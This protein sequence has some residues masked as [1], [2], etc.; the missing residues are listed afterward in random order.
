ME[1]LAPL[2]VAHII[3]VAVD[4]RDFDAMIQDVAKIFEVATASVI[5][6]RLKRIEDGVD[7]DREVDGYAEGLLHP[8]LV[9]E[10]DEVVGREWIRVEVCD[11]IRVALCPTSVRVEIGPNEPTGRSKATY[12][13]RRDV[14]TLDRVGTEV[15]RVHTGLVHSGVVVQVARIQFAC[16][17]ATLDDG[18]TTAARPLERMDGIIILRLVDRLEPVSVLEG[19]LR[20]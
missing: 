3:S 6:R 2:T 1:A 9:Q 14:G 16:S 13:A 7:A 17:V 12:S 18:I 20:E 4:Q 10:A 8:M 15:D 11:V 19:E 5:A